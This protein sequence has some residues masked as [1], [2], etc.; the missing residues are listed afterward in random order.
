ML[1]N[2][3]NDHTKIP[4]FVMSFTFLTGMTSYLFSVAIYADGMQRY[5]WRH[6]RIDRYE[7]R[8]STVA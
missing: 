6:H 8:I 4:T 2:P 5:R 1:L 7:N 3:N